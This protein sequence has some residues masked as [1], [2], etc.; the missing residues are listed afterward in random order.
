MPT[1]AI[2]GTRFEPTYQMLPLA[3]EGCARVVDRLL[4]KGKSS[5]W[6]RTPPPT[7][8]RSIGVRKN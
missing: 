6:T 1:Y 2:D 3:I 8:R 7:T 4:S 5:E